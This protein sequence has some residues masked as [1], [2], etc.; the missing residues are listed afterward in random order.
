MRD[1]GRVRWTIPIPITVLLVAA[2]GCSSGHP[3]AK[4]V[5]LSENGRI[6]ELRMD[7]SSRV[8][9]IAFT[10]KPDAERRGGESGGPPFRA[11]G[12]E[13]SRKRKDDAFPLLETPRGRS[14]PS[15]KTV[16]W[17]N[18]RTGTLGTFYTSSPHYSESHGVRIGMKTAE[19]ER[20]L[21]KRVIVGCEENIYLGKAPLT[22]AFA[23]GAPHRT[24]ASSALHLIGGHVYAFALQGRDSVG[25]FDCL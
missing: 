19:A 6:G 14:G 3:S 9:V 13:C 1:W 20:L 17:I 16:F 12:Y 15:C 4:R 10:G 5:V 2:A 21:S 25:I 23:G 22:I 24:S 18:S 7:R 8:N 11:L